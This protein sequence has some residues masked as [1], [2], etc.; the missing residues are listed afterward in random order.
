LPL[1]APLLAV[2]VVA[3]LNLRPLVSVRVLTSRSPALPLGIWL[4]AGGAGGALLSATATA[5]AL[6]QGRR[7]P[8]SRSVREPQDAS[9]AWFAPDGPTGRGSAGSAEETDEILR[10]AAG[11][12]GWPQ[13][14]PER[15]PG[16]PAPTVSV[17]FRVLRRPQ[18]S[19]PTGSGGPS[20][21]SAASS[22]APVRPETS[23]GNGMQ[24]QDDWNAVDEEDW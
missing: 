6:R 13:A 18:L 2:L 5:L 22:P 12:D 8:R 14:G 9:P 19:S 15:S 10:P 7:R 4:A 3:V 20:A 17:P 24:S 21:A 16:E 11:W 1:L 23:A